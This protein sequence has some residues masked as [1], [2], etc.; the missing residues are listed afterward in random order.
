ML[1]CRRGAG[2]VFCLSSLISICLSHSLH[3]LLHAG[4]RERERR[5]SLLI[6]HPKY[7]YDS[8]IN[9]VSLL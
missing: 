1:D 7:E 6:K 2:Y 4:C 8:L 3:L 9:V 5:C